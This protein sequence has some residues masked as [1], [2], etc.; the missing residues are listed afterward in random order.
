MAR[1]AFNGVDLCRG[2]HLQQFTRLLADILDA[3]VAWNVIRH[4][5]ERR[6]EIG[7]EQSVLVAEYEKLKRIEHRLLYRLHV[8]ILR[9]QK[10]KLLFEHQCAGWNGSENGIALARQFGQLWNIDCLEPVSYTHL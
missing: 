1:A 5:A 2:H 4:L 10:R 3:R 8:V 9:K 7:P 6:L